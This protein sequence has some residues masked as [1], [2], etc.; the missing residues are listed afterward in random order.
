MPSALFLRNSPIGRSTT[1]E[2]PKSPTV[3][4]IPSLSKHNTHGSIV[5]PESDKEEYEPSSSTVLTSLDTIIKES[6]L[7]L[8][9]EFNEGEK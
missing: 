2:K 5:D 6:F 3:L 8:Q 7:Q 1:K 9:L 4:P